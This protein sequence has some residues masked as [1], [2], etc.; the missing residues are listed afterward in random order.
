MKEKQGNLEKLFE[1]VKKGES[2][3]D[4]HFYLNYQCLNCGVKYGREIS[5]CHGCGSHSIAQIKP[6]YQSLMG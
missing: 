2:M 4:I 3:P 5:H 1:P 6:E